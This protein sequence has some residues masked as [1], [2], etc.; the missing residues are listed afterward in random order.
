MEKARREECYTETTR[1]YN[2]YAFD[3]VEKR[4][5]NHKKKTVSNYMKGDLIRADILTGELLHLHNTQ[6]FVHF[7]KK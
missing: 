4:H 7:D 1:Q 5:K 2:E 3:A 6:S